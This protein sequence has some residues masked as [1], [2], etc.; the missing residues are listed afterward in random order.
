MKNINVDC[1]NYN[2]KEV[3]YQATNHCHDGDHT[4]WIDHCQDGNHCQDRDPCQDVDEHADG[5]NHRTVLI[6]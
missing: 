1:V 4:V 2:Q 6:H 3:Y 5:Q